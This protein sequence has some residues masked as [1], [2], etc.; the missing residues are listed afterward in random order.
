MYY[1]YDDEVLKR[2]QDAER[3]VLSDFIS[4]CERHNIRYFACGGTCLGAVRHGDFIPWDDDVDIGMLRED[5]DKFLA[6][7]KEEYGDKY[8]L[9]TPETENHYYC[10]IPKFYNKNTRY[11]SEIADAVGI[12]DMGIFIEIFV[13]ENVYNDEKWLSRKIKKCKM[14]EH[15]HFVVAAKKIPVIGKGISSYIV[16]AIRKMIWLVM[17]GMHI[18]LQQT[19]HSFVRTSKMKE[20][21]EWASVFSFH[22]TKQSMV[23][24]SD[25]FPVKKLH[26]GDIQIAVPNNYK[27][28]LA[29]LYGDYMQL[30]SEDKRWNQ[31]PVMI[32]FEGEEGIKLR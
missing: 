25:L 18:S 21:S 32:Q 20:E 28:Y 22:T 8:E 7:A 17:K 24:K 26:F 30:P 19:N 2:L 10:F 9:S 3:Q 13:W 16:F 15:F 27:E 31:A 23:K 12:K 6:V 1:K 29:N 5:Y 14:I 11:I 4:I